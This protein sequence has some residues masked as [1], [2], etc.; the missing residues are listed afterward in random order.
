MEN[1][2]RKSP[3]C[4]ISWILLLAAMCICNCA[5]QVS[6]RSF[7]DWMCSA[8]GRWITKGNFK[9][10]SYAPFSSPQVK[11]G[12]SACRNR[13]FP[14]MKCTFRFLA[15]AKHLIYVEFASVSLDGRCNED[16]IDIDMRH[17]VRRVCG[18]PRLTYDI[19]DGGEMT[20]TFRSNRQNQCAGFTGYFTAFL[21]DSAG[22]KR[23]S[24]SQEVLLSRLKLLYT[25]QDLVHRALRSTAAT[26]HYNTR[27]VQSRQYTSRYSLLRLNL[28]MMLFRE[29]KLPYLMSCRSRVMKDLWGQSPCAICK[30]KEIYNCRCRVPSSYSG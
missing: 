1:S 20:V 26:T 5:V 19:T 16:Y 7:G 21:D 24:L 25:S 15:P 13:Y 2:V 3:A 4:C 23:R 17:G 30:R 29:R 14:N 18:K 12:S 10:S 28:K 22:R 8:S 27:S 6:G 9:D 11:T